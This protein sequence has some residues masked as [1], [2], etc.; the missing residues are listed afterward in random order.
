M[1]V[2]YVDGRPMPFSSSSLMS[3][4]WVNAAAAA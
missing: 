2:A 4:A 1:I 3:V